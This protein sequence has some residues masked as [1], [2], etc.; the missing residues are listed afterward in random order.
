MA[1]FITTSPTYMS[2]YIKF[3]I[4]ICFKTRVHNKLKKYGCSR[5]KP[6]NV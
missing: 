4:N 3:A 5:H 2:V 1:N 6:V